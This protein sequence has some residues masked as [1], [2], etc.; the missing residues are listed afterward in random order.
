MK[1]ATRPTAIPHPWYLHLDSTNA[2]LDV[3]LGEIPVPDE[4]LPALAIASVGILG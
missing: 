1:T 4:G 2:R 3:P